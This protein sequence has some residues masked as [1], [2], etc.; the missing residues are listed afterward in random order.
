MNTPQSITTIALLFVAAAAPSLAQQNEAELK[1]RILVQAQSVSAS[2]YAF[3]RTTHNEARWNR[4][5]FKHVRIE[6]F[7]ATKLPDA[8]WTLVSVD[9]APPSAA[10]LKECRNEAAKRGVVPA[11][12]GAVI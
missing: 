6:Q 2:D 1:Q 7:D 12:K 3:T 5:I 4:I 11:S 8:R 9:G 10:A